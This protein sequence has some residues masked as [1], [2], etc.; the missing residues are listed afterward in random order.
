MKIFYFMPMVLTKIIGRECK[1]IAFHQISHFPKDPCFGNIYIYISEKFH[2]LEE[3]RVITSASSGGGWREV[4]TQRIC[5]S[6]VPQNRASA[7]L[8]RGSTCMF[9][10]PGDLLKPDT[11]HR[12]C[13]C[14]LASSCTCW[15]CHCDVLQ[16]ALVLQAEKDGLV[17]EGDLSTKVWSV[18]LSDGQSDFR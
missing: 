4:E 18:T 14:S 13:W 7:L 8:L 17:R 6:S 11:A 9:P 15:H 2:D 16:N 1:G 5:T 12:A 3:L 10:I